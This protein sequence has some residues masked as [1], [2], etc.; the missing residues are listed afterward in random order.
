MPSKYLQLLKS[1]FR[2]IGLNTFDGGT[3]SILK[4]ELTQVATSRYYSTTLSSR[5]GMRKERKDIKAPTAEKMRHSLSNDK[6][7]LS[8]ENSMKGRAS[9]KSPTVYRNANCG[10]GDGP[11]GILDSLRTLEKTD[12]KFRKLIHISSNIDTLIYAYELI[13]NKAGNMTPAVD[14]ETLDGIDRKWFEDT[15]LAL[16]QGTFKFR[17]GRRVE[18]PKPRGGTRPLTVGSPRD[19]IVQKAVELVLSH[20]Y[21]EKLKRF[22]DKVHGF[23][24]NRSCH[25]ALKQIKYTWTATP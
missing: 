4:L 16:R 23:R 3:R 1:S 10:A 7:S 24:P 5:E 12:G 20:V 2:S 14:M 13:R 8:E 21:E 25:T 17:E 9:P 19:K 11:Q 18:I 22:S 15:S 6:L